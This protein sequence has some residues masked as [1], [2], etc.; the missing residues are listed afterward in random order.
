MENVPVQQL[1]VCLLSAVQAKIK[2]KRGS[3]EL[4]FIVLVLLPH[5]LLRP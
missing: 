1:D 3:T 5:L 2:I 4:F